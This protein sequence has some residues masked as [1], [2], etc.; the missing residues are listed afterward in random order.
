MDAVSLCQVFRATM[1]ERSK[2]KPAVPLRHE[3]PRM[4]LSSRKNWVQENTA[5][6]IPLQK[7]IEQPA[8]VRRRCGR[9]GRSGTRRKCTLE[10]AFVQVPAEFVRAT[11]PRYFIPPL[12][13][14]TI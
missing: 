4:G 7:R 11:L 14:W 2:L 6:V 1:R 9:C 5:S 13:R 3:R 10:T 8:R 12:L